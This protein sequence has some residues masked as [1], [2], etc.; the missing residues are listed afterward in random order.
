MLIPTTIYNRPSVQQPA[1]MSA[2]SSV[3]A[4]SVSLTA[5]PSGLIVG[6][7]V[8]IDC[9]TSQC[10]IRRVTNVTG[11]TVTVSRLLFA[12]AANDVFVIVSDSNV[13]TAFFN[14]Q[15]DGTDEWQILQRLFIETGGN[16]PLTIRGD[17]RSYFF[18]QPIVVDSN[19]RVQ[20]LRVTTRSGFAP[21]AATGAAVMVGNGSFYINAVA[22]T[23][24][25]T[26]TESDHVT[27]AS[28]N[29]GVSNTITFSN[30]YG[31]TLPGGVTSGKV[32]YVLTTPTSSTFTVSVTDGG[33]VLDVTSDGTGW[34]VNSVTDGLSR[35][36]WESFHLV[37]A[38]ADLNGLWASLQQPSW[39]RNLRIQMT[40]AASTLD[41]ASGFVLDGQLSYHDNLQIDTV[42]NT[43]GVKVTGSGHVIRGFSDNGDGTST[44]TGA[45]FTEAQSCTMLNPWTENVGCGIRISGV[46][47]SVEIGGAWLGVMNDSSYPML[48]V[49]DDTTSYRTGL[50]RVQADDLIL[51]QDTARSIT[52]R[53]FAGVDS[54]VDN[55][56]VFGGL[57]QPYGANAP[58]L[59]ERSH[60]LTSTSATITHYQGFLEINATGGAKTM[61]LPA[62]T[63]W[64][65][66]QVTVCNAST[67]GSNLVTVNCTGGDT[68]DG[69]ASVTLAVGET[70]TFVSCGGLYRRADQ[71]LPGTLQT[72][73]ATNVT[74]DRTYDANATTLDEVAD[75][76]GT[77]IADLR[78]RR[79]VA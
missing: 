54:V 72:Y 58:H 39:T 77:L 44:T 73:A 12:H 56:Q 36:H 62:T 70:M 76:L 15:A 30:P 16:A 18:Q 7:V 3:G 13:P 68:I 21:V 28:H 32:Y 2:N 52:L 29:L 69:A 33:S 27:P 5:L 4:T 67:S 47:R 35:I 64:L 17:Q 51:V 9:F 66:W 43:I 45:V 10:E 14:L 11:T 53:S 63:G 74:T 61:T 38:I 26:A 79:I 34:S 75:V 6:S 59:H 22:S 71:F 8:A 19:S 20:N 50:M 42:A 23:N 65:G 78:T 25:F 40:A 31:E 46:S 60:V 57:T 41:A 24:V 55:G 48:Q 49:T 37:D 1:S